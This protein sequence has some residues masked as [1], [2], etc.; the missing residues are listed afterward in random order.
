M[1]YHRKARKRTVTPFFA[2][3]ITSMTD[4]FTMLLVFLLQSFAASDVH[5]DTESGM[6]LP[7]SSSLV[8]PTRSTQVL[9][10]KN[11]IRVDGQVVVQFES[12]SLKPGDLD[13]KNKNIIAPLL[14][15]LKEKLTKIEANIEAKKLAAQLPKV[16]VA[17]NAGPSATQE[18]LTD[19][20]LLLQAESSADMAK[21]EP[22]FT[23][24]SAAGFAKVKL[25]TVVGR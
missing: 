22:Y 3:N 14:T 15:T 16:P 18:P 2:L 23:T 5:I 12:G 10:G 19:D 13:P 25:A 24:I 21:L 20:S 9:V 11:D 8:N 7:L 17:A 4:M 6:T 1:T